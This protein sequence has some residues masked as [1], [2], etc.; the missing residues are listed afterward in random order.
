MNFKYFMQGVVKG[1]LGFYAG[2][3]AFYAAMLFIVNTVLWIC[4]DESEMFYQPVW[5]IFKLM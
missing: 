2:A 5:N 3:A 1:F 4:W